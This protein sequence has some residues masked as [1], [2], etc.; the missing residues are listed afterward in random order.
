MFLR[1]DREPLKKSI[2]LQP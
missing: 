2:G 1:W